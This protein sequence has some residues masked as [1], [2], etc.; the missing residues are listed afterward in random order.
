MGTPAEAANSASLRRDETVAQSVTAITSANPTRMR[1]AG[2]ATPGWQDTYG[3]WL[4]L[5]DLVIV[6][7]AAGIAQLIRFGS[8][9]SSVSAAL[10][11]RITYTEVSIALVIGWM[12]ALAIN[13]ARS[14]RVIGSGIEEYRRVWWATISTFGTVAIISMLFNIALK[15]T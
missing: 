12:A 15:T 11:H 6:V 5:T 2:S 1:A 9:S 10:G 8:S 7:A 3:R 4:A 13:G 14:T